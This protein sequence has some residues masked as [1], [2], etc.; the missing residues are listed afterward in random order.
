MVQCEAGRSRTARVRGK[1]QLQDLK[2]L[3]PDDRDWSGDGQARCR[4]GEIGRGQSDLARHARR[5]AIQ[6]CFGPLIAHDCQ[7]IIR[8]AFAGG[9]GP[10]RGRC[11]MMMSGL[12][13]RGRDAQGAEGDQRRDRLNSGKFQQVVPR[14]GRHPPEYGDGAKTWRSHALRQYFLRN[15]LADIQ[16]LQICTFQDASAI[17]GSIIDGEREW[18]WTDPAAFSSE[19]PKASRFNPAKMRNEIRRQRAAR[20]RQAAAMRKLLRSYII[21]QVDGWNG[22]S[23]TKARSGSPQNEHGQDNACCYVCRLHQPVSPAIPVV[24]HC[25]PS[26]SDRLGAK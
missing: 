2:R 24:S 15:T 8:S 3:R 5:S 14:D 26:V 12:G 10:F 7:I 11:L 20:T 13:E 21:D 17:K 23:Q 9:H 18:T 25:R 22:L 1:L 16:N 6:V 19:Y 4:A